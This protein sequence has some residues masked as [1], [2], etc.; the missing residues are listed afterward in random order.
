MTIQSPENS[1]GYDE[2]VAR[3][4]ELMAVFARHDPKTWPISAKALDLE[5]HTGKV[6]QAALEKEGY[7]PTHAAVDGLGVELATLFF[8]CLDLARDFG[9]NFKGEFSKFLVDSEQKLKKGGV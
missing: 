1:A 2:L 8:I 3:A 7:K 4:Y 6:A 5:S 9:L